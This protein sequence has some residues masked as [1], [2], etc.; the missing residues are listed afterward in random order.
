MGDHGVKKIF[1]LR[2]GFE[3][4]FFVLGNQ[5]LIQTFDQ[6]FRFKPDLDIR[7]DAV[8]DQKIHDPVHFFKIIVDDIQLQLF[9][10]N[11]PEADVFEVQFM[12]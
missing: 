8:M 12:F 7:M 2:I 9:G 6:H 1:G 5:I 3:Q 11:V 10:I 4:D